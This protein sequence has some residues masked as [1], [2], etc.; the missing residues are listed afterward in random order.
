MGENSVQ[1]TY[2]NAHRCVEQYTYIDM[3]GYSQN[4]EYSP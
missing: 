2:R 4:V 1:T 3:V